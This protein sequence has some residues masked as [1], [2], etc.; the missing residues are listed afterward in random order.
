M[1][2]RD[3]TAQGW[4]DLEA[5][6]AVNFT[7][8]AAPFV[9]LKGD[10]LYRVYGGAANIKGAYWSPSPPAPGST[11]GDW[12]GSNA[13]EYSWN[14]GANVASYTAENDIPLWKGGVE[15]QP[16]Q[17][18]DSVPLPDYWLVGGGTQFFFPFWLINNFAPVPCGPTPWQGA[19]IAETAGAPAQL[20]AT[21]ADFDPA[22]KQAS[23]AFRVSLLA[24][25]LR[26]SADILRQTATAD[27]SAS[28]DGVIA[29]LMN[30]ANI[31]LNNIG[32]DPKVVSTEVRSQ[33]GLARYV[34]IGAETPDGD[35]AT[36]LLNDVIQGAAELSGK[37]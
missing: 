16:A 8:G 19:I 5:K 15:S 22:D 23:Q 36:R 33:L 7:L 24:D 20:V 29:N 26:H 27:D 21:A 6:N 25:A 4:P 13:I 28:L 17:S 37:T 2:F 10:T 31:I 14:S 34:M 35:N 18:M 32:G 3:V 11:E 1:P 30:S 9:L 12:R